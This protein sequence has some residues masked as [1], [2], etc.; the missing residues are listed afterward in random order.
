VDKALASNWQTKGKTIKPLSIFTEEVEVW[1][2]LEMVN[3]MVLYS[4]LFLYSGGWKA[5]RKKIRPEQLKRDWR[6]LL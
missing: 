6:L 5:H 2:S 3:E 1:G 4:G